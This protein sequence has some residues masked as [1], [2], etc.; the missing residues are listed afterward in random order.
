[1][2]VNDADDVRRHATWVDWD[3]VA[4]FGERLMRLELARR[5]DFTSRPSSSHSPEPTHLAVISIIA[6]VNGE[7][8]SSGL[9]D[10]PE[11]HNVTI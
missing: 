6:A 7:Q 11:H 10:K 8:R 9:R 4:I 5:M 3:S 1:M 2:R